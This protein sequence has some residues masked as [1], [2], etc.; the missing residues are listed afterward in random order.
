MAGNA[1]KSNEISQLILADEDGQDRIAELIAETEGAFR[2]GNPLEAAK[3][4]GNFSSLQQNLEQRRDLRA[5]QL[6]CQL[7]KSKNSAELFEFILALN[8]PQLMDDCFEMVAALSVKHGL[9]SDIWEQHERS[10]LTP[11]QKVAFYRG[12]VAGIVAVKHAGS[13]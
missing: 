7:L 10:R 3:A 11:T 12:L 4:L 8:D 13:K 5:L 6:A 2:S 9:A 1:S